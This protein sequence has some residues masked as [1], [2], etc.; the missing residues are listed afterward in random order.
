MPPAQELGG[1]DFRPGLGLVDEGDE[2]DDDIPVFLRDDDDGEIS[3]AVRKA[4]PGFDRRQ[5]DPG[6][7]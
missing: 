6:A 1:Y 2:S 4:Y 5:Q 3:R 7:Y